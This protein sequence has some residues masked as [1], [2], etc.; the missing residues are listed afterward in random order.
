MQTVGKFI[1]GLIGGAIA[2]TYLWHFIC[3]IRAGRPK[4][5]NWG[6]DN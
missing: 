6:Q 4:T 3:W 2:G 1:V 5:K